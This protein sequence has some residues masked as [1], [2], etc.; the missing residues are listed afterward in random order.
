MLLLFIILAT[1]IAYLHKPASIDFSD[2]FL[3]FFVAISV[4]ILIIAQLYKKTNDFIKKYNNLIHLNNTLSGGIVT[5]A[6]DANL[7]IIYANDSY[8]D[9]IGYS[10][11]EVAQKFNNSGIPFLGITSLKELINTTND[12]DQLR[13]SLSYDFELKKNDGSIIW[14]QANC[15]RLESNLKYDCISYLII[16]ITNSKKYQQELL[17]EKERYHIATEL[18]NDIIFEYDIASDTLNHA[19]KYQLTFGRPPLISDFCLNC[20]KTKLVTPTSLPALKLFCQDL[21]S[22]KPTMSAELQI[23]DRNNNFTWFHIKG[24]TIY[25]KTSKPLK[26]VGKIVNIDSQKQA[27]NSLYNKACRDPLTGLYNKTIT[28]SLIENI[29]DINYCSNSLHSH[30][31][32]VI[33]I[34]NFKSVNDNLGHL[35]GDDVLINITTQLKAL[36]GEG[37]IIGRIGGDEFVVFMPEISSWAEVSGKINAIS[38]VLRYTYSD[39]DKECNV[40]GSIGV[41]VYPYDGSNYLELFKAADTA[42]YDIKAHGK[43]S[44]ATASNPDIYI[45][46][47]V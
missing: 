31:F 12:K 40:S 2:S 47:I 45:N 16:D 23:L 20:D 28:R 15:Q 9:I 21:R 38:Q 7:S 30:A 46:S 36:F 29:L 24:Q 43:N 41:S 13:K 6:L 25:D 14:L 39:H 1:V 32:L 10:R 33:D 22:G 8:Y 42:L 11:Q 3:I 44:F 34:D 19:N 26:V 17:L 18:T 5:Y 27:L 35:V 37:N 4:I